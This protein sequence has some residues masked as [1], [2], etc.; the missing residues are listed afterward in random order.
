MDESTEYKYEIPEYLEES[1]YNEKQVKEIDK[2]HDKMF[3]KILE[4]KEEM[5]DLINNFLKIKEKIKPENLIQCHTD[6][7]TNKYQERHS[8]I[9]Y[10]LK[11]KPIYFLVEH[12]STVD[13]EMP[14]RI[15]RIYRTNNAKG[16]NRA[17]L[18]NSSTNS[19][20]YRFPKMECKN[21]FWRK[22]IQF[23]TIWRI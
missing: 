8:D 5:A 21:K 16:K 3:R 1:G 2:K 10:K 19:N 6:F 15:M 9:V 17:D 20:I 13:K 23:K 12:Q 22:A 18:S 4:K 14:E 11:D 7:I